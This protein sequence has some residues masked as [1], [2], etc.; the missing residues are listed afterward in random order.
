MIT[1]TEKEL[2][3]HQLANIDWDSP[4]VTEAQRVSFELLHISGAIKSQAER[5]VLAGE[6]LQTG[7]VDGEANWL[8]DD[9]SADLADALERLD[10]IR[11]RLF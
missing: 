10:T 11:A 2:L 1:Q 3:R 7:D 5:V 8:L 4:V 9:I 6:N